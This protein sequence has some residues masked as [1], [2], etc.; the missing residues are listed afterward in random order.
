MVDEVTPRR[1]VIAVSLLLSLGAMAGDPLLAS[2]ERSFEVTDADVRPLDPMPLEEA[3]SLAQRTSSQLP[4][5]ESIKLL[6]RVLAQE[7]RPELRKEALFW[8]GQSRSPDALD[9]V[10]RI[11][12]Q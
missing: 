5:P 11:L 9:I 2:L 10:T 4:E 1:I 6:S 8:I 3:A 12:N 7:Q